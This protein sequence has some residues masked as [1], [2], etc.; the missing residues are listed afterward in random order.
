MNEL[1]RAVNIKKNFMLGEV[2]LKVIK[3]IDFC[4]YEGEFVVVL[5]PSGSG[6]STVLNLLGGIDQV[7]A[8]ELYFRGK[9][10]HQADE[11]KLTAYRRANI[12][13][14]F[15]FYNLVPDLT[16][17]E[18]IEMAAEISR[19][20][21]DCGQLLE[22][23]GLLDQAGSFPS[24][25]SG[26]QQ[27][28]VAIA[29]ALAKNPD[30]LLCDEPTGALDTKTGAQVLELLADFNRKYQKTV[31]VVTHNEQISQIGNRTFY[32]RD[33]YLDRVAVNEHPVS[34]AEVEW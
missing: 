14:I 13:F 24:K 32:I 9:P 16:A 5:G 27:Q 31:V 4:L 18:N 22:Q 21:L 20:P 1:V 25:M 17:R 23:V 19:Q 34:P 7:S 29:R 3:G 15:Q 6:K 33:G 28:R 26:G 11:Q 12:G 30:L 2:E 8:G 10:I